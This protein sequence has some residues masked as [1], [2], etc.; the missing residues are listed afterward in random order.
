MK[1]ITYLCSLQP[2]QHDTS[3]FW[4]RALRSLIVA[5]AV[6]TLMQSSVVF[7]DGPEKCED[8]YPPPCVVCKDG[9][10]PPC[11]LEPETYTGDRCG[12]ACGDSGPIVVDYAQVVGSLG[13][14]GGGE[15]DG[16]SSSCENASALN[17]TV[18]L[19]ASSAMIESGRQKSRAACAQD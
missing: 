14:E 13:L 12:S 17:N 2:D 18:K 6:S 9:N 8:G 16:S 7:A 15:L 4:A 11:E 19:F 5:I 1:P 3:K 10:S